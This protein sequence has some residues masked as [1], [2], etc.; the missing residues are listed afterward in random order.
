M[1]LH[2]LTIRRRLLVIFIL[3]VFVGGAVQ[4]MIAGRQLEAATLEF[5]QH[6]LET[7]ALL[8]STTFS[9]PLSHLLEGESDDG[10]GRTLSALQQ[11]VGHNYL[12]LDTSYRAIG[13]TANSGYQLGR[14]VSVTPELTQA[15]S[16][17]IGADIRP[18]SAAEATLYLAV[19][20]QH[21]GDMLGYLV[22][23]EPMQPAYD[24]VNRR[25]AELAVATLPVIGLVIA[26]SLWVSGSISKPI[27][28][29]RNSALLMAKGHLQ[30]RIPI[31]S[32][33]EIGQLAESFNYMA[34]QIEALMKTQRSFVSNAAHELRTPLMT[35]K[36]RAEALAEENL[37]S[38]ERDT[39]LKEIQQEVDHMAR[40]VSSLLILARIDEGRHPPDK[41]TTDTVS[42][43]HD[44]IRN[45]R[46][47]AQAKGLTF[48][49]DIDPNLPEL[50][51]SPNDLRLVLDNLFSN[52]IKYTP[53]GRVS[54]KVR[55][56]HKTFSFEISDTGHGFPAEQGPRLFERFYRSETVRAQITGYGLGLSIVKA[57]VD[58]YG[59]RI[60][61]TSEGTGKGAVFTVHLPG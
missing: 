28:H 34:S 33:D 43:L 46:I 24:D 49:A 35:L 42:T 40:L 3:I 14:Q 61:A 2:R 16:E 8:V 32:Q 13:Y 25:Y 4:F 31:T 27:Q 37:T 57:I 9:E 56:Q 19:S 22:L 15:R 30:T 7:D 5:H 47:E 53:Q 11:Q 38:T 48:Q 29:L 26:A 55:H 36:L 18:N 39:Y 20:I 60:E 17:G 23:S 50:P 21:E 52:A 59:G 12:I 1:M 44:I 41:T 45:W 51:M 6:H 58:H 54:L 10:L